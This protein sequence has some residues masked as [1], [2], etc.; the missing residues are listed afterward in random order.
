MLST[1]HKCSY[2]PPTSKNRPRRCSASMHGVPPI[3]KS[4]RHEA[5]SS[6]ALMEASSV[7]STDTRSRPAIARPESTVLLPGRASSSTS[8]LGFSF[9]SS[10]AAAAR[11]GWCGARVFSAKPL[12]RSRSSLHRQLLLCRTARLP[13]S[14]SPLQIREQ[15]GSDC[16]WGICHCW[17]G[18]RHI[19]VGK[20]MGAQETGPQECVICCSCVVR[21]LPMSQQQACNWQYLHC[22][23]LA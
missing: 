8:T 15:Q 20:G 12:L 23:T 13:A 6:P 11:S 18:L 4:T 9:L 7:S 22:R 16:T 10:A 3:P 21:E 5:T 1:T 14:N 17:A 19:H 2:L